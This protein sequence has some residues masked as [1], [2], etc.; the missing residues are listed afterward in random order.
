[1][2]TSL[3]YAYAK[4][5]LRLLN[6]CSA[7]RHLFKEPILVYNYEVVPVVKGLVYR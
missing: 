5:F 3:C 7:P 1:M 4:H 6:T 2:L